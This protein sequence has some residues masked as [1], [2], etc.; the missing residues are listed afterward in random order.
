MVFQ[1]FPKKL[2]TQVH[3]KINQLRLENYLKR[4]KTKQLLKLPL[5]LKKYETKFADIYNLL[6]YK[7]STIEG[8]EMYFETLNHLTK[9]HPSLSH[10]YGP[11]N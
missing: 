3:S 10:F 9:I 11:Q 6:F 1:T 5:S 7:C 2:L 8:L 4:M